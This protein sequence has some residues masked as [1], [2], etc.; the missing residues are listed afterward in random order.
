MQIIPVDNYVTMNMTDLQRVINDAAKTAFEKAAQYFRGG[1]WNLDNEIAQQTEM[2]C[3]EGDDNMAKERIKRRITIDGQTRWVTATN[4]N[5]YIA[6]ALK[7]MNLTQTQTPTAK[8]EFRKYAETW[9]EVFSKPNVS[10]TTGITYERQMK[11]YIFPVLG[12]M[13]IEDITTNDV[14]MVFNAMDTNGTPKKKATKDKVKMVLNMIL[15]HAVEEGIINKNPLHSSAVRI[16][17]LPSET[18]RPYS[19]EQMKHIAA[20]IA[21][22]K[23]P[24]DR[25][26]IS[27][28]ALHPM[29]LEE[30]LGLRWCDIDL[31]ND[32]I[33]INNTVIHPSRN[34]G[35]F[36][37]MTKTD[38]SRRTISMVPQIKKYL[39]TGDTEDFVVGGK[40]MQ[41]YQNVQDMCERIQKDLDFD[42]PITPRRFRTTVLTDIYDQ[43][44]DIKQTQAAAGH[45]TAAMTLKH[46]VKGRELNRDTA[47]PIANTYGLM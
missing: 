19:V 30:V 13:Y 3:N 35:L 36:R 16:K 1:T 17:G 2:P 24:K 31:D 14:Q 27:L 26:F 29:R 6:N 38:Q 46:Y 40:V 4:E 43:T 39:E 20:H 22:V 28:L 12:D 42:E 33:H 41:S 25:A 11:L 45:T 32:L 8:H 34:Q 9:F 37:E 44:K 10:V 47:T 18:T 5:D 21:D 7:A 23:N 15:Q